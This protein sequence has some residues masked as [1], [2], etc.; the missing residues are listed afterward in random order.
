MNV[1]PAFASS[2]VGFHTACSKSHSRSSTE[3]RKQAAESRSSH[4]NVANGSQPF[5][6]RASRR[7]LAALT[8]ALH[9]A[10]GR[11][12]RCPCA[13]LL[14]RRGRGPVNVHEGGGNTG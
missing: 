9:R 6:R 3:F 5:R 4:R 8:A 7:R 10:R 14:R 13:F 1:S 11:Q 12:T 2:C